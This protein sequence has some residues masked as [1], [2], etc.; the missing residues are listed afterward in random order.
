MSHLAHVRALEAAGLIRLAT[1]QPDLEYTFRHAL[2]QEAVYHTLSK[3]ARMGTHRAVADVLAAQADS[4]PLG[5]LAFH[6]AEAG[7][8][9]QA[10]DYAWR[11]GAHEQAMYAPREALAYF[12]QA[13]AAARQLRAPP[14]WG[15][16]RARG[17]A[18]NTLGRID[19]ARTDY[20]LALSQ[21]RAGGDPRAEWQSLL[22]LGFLWVARDYEQAGEYFRAALELSRAMGDPAS[23]GHS[24]NRVG[25]W[26]M[27]NQDPLEA[28]G[29]HEEALTIFENLNDRHSLAETLDLLGITSALLGDYVASSRYYPRAIG[30]F[31]EA[32]DRPGLISA[33]TV[34]LLRG[35]TYETDLLVNENLSVDEIR[36]TG[37]EILSIARAI[38]LRS[39]ETFA[40]GT[41]AI[42][43]GPRGEFAR[44]LRMAEEALRIAEEIQ[45]WPWAAA[46]HYSL[47]TLH[48]DLLALPLA[49]QHLEAGLALARQ[50][51]T[52]IWITNIGGTLGQ[53]YVAHHRQADPARAVPAWH[54]RPLSEWPALLAQAQ[55]VLDQA[56][57]PDAPLRNGMAGIVWH[58]RAQLALACGDPGRALEMAEALRAFSAAPYEQEVPVPGVLRLRAEALAALGRTVEAVADLEAARDR[59]RELGAAYQLWRIERHLASLYADLGQPQR[60]EAARAAWHAQVAG[61]AQQVPAGELRD[62]FLEK[63]HIVG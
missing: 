40:L 34:Y 55:A 26:Y 23:L 58:A 8:W 4:A 21:A 61:L 37:D 49:Q 16:L 52:R 38:G 54:T 50:A 6:Y 53:V 57:R 35:L 20:E 11:A 10:R 30:L 19:A 12:D 48:A 31:R 46:A 3:F 32:G 13:L 9:E 5:D 29:Y 18:L 56:L 7:Q 63:A 2:V 22:D 25:N 1:T 14:P 15:L 24:L 39:A 17:Q 62:N 51:N 33:L 47:G 41:L 28:R 42:L 45:H 60:A 36:R 27:N 59:A 44:A 43:L